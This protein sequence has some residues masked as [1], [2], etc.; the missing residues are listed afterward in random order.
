MQL[1][2]FLLDQFKALGQ[3]HIFKYWGAL[4]DKERQHL[5]FQAQKID[6]NILRSLL[7][8]LSH[9]N[10]TQSLA[11]TLEPPEKI[12]HY[13][14][15]GS[16]DEWKAA[17]AVGEAII[18]AQKVVALTVAG[19]QATRLGGVIPKGLLGV[20]PCQ[21]KSLFQL[22]AEK[23][24]ATERRYH[25]TIPWLVMTSPF[26]RKPI[27]VFF[28]ENHYFGLEKVYFFEQSFLPVLSQEG[29][30][31]LET[32]CTLAMN[33]NGHGGVFEA[34]LASG[35]LETLKG[36]GYQYI[37]YF[38]VD[39]PLVHGVDPYFLG[40]HHLAQSSFSTKV[41]AKAYPEEKV[42]VFCKK[43]GCLQVVEYSHLPKEKSMEQDEAGHLKYRWSNTAIHLLN[44]D[45]ME[46]MGLKEE[47]C[48][49]YRHAL[50]SVPI[51]EEEI[52]DA[53]GAARVEAIKFER[54]IF[55]ALQYAK[56]PL[57]LEVLREEEFSPIKN[58]SG[59]DS[60]ETAQKD[61]VRLF[62]QWLLKAGVAESVLKTIQE[63]EISPLFADTE[64]LFLQKWQDLPKKPCL[65]EGFYLE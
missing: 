48:L 7:S 40:F 38:Q 36:Q 3:E 1:P 35:L 33:P 25:I 61:Q 23:L 18:Q 45:F 10:F 51:Y 43:H 28:K 64:E 65:S 27:E 50:K 39:N 32:P 52:L 19:G 17:K 60:L 11:E 13:Q 8:E 41:V 42:G 15:G 30:L 26:N 57:L 16:L 44:L 2:S 31:L 12:S 6:L 4:D 49:P 46:H 59:K 14:R 63:L 29:K 54:F 5:L 55:D 34:L 20:S 58:Y 22:F 62:K 24:K 21:Q 56:N 37:S 47:T 9:L 53:Q